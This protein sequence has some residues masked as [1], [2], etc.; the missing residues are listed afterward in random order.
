MEK[1][2]V[3]IVKNLVLKDVDIF[4][5]YCAFRKTDDFFDTHVSSNF[6]G[7]QTVYDLEV[8]TNVAKLTELQSKCV[9][10]PNNRKY[11]L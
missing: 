8:Q 4:I 5:V 11:W 2:N 7:I 10:F 3:V 6:L 1:Y 9:L